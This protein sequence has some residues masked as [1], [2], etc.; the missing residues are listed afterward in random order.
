MKRKSKKDNPAIALRK[1]GIVPRDLSSV[2]RA[3]SYWRSTHRWIPVVSLWI[4]MCCL[5]A[6]LGALTCLIIVFTRPRPV[7]LVS[8]PDG[9]T[10]CSM[11]P[12]DPKT[13]RVIPRPSAEADLCAQLS[14]RAGRGTDEQN[15]VFAK[16]VQQEA[17]VEQ[18]DPLSDQATGLNSSAP[19]P[20]AAPSS[21]PAAP[22]PEAPIV[23]PQAS[24]PAQPATQQPV[25]GV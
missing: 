11:P 3:G 12:L 9:L 5:V 6:L 25:G 21:T 7:L 19:S 10:L 23:P 14:T 22:S 18:M 16:Q 4:K 13:S 1:I 20:E 15:L 24:N 17:K 8:F 2:E